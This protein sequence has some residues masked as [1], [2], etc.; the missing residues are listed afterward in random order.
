VFSDKGSEILLW[1]MGK[2]YII[3]SFG[4]YN[5]KQFLLFKK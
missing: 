2:P 3:E 1:Y 5:L 4:F